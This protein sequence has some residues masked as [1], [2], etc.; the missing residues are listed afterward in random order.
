[1]K[2]YLLFFFSFTILLC[3]NQASVLKKKTV[4]VASYNV[5]FFEGGVAGIKATIAKIDPDIIALQ[6]VLVKDGVP[7]S[8]RIARSL[9]Y[10]HSSSSP[11]VNFGSTQWVLSFLSK[12]PVT[13]T[14]QIR[15][16]SRRAYQVSIFI[17][18]TEIM[19]T[20]LHLSPFVWSKGN[21]LA[22]N[23]QRSRVRQSEI[24]ALVRWIG[25]PNGPSVLLGDFN[26]LP[27][28][29]ELDP[30]LA[31]S[32][33]DVYDTLKQKREGTFKVKKYII[34]TVKRYLPHM[35]IGTVIPFDYIL[36]GGKIGVQSVRV[37]QSTASDH[38]PIVA[39][40][41]IDGTGAERK[42]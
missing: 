37:V 24:Q 20:T 8:L 14:K 33:A 9:K 40:I 42:N 34:K 12:Y 15:L 5:H 36:T 21:L 2:A 18:G 4:R 7:Y 17:G 41:Q 39:E 23:M 35:P 19:F 26:S 11:Y 31:M 22:A 1:M 38:L 3:N 10:H 29:G 30:V 32:Y 6:E 28:M 27:F 25:R 13:G 16:R